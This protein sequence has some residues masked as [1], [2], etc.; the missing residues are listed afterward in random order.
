MSTMSVVASRYA[1]ALIEAL[2]AD[3]AQSADAGLDQ[4]RRIE[5]LLEI[6][7]DARKLLVNPVIPSARRR[8]FVGEINRSLGL[9]ARVGRLLGLI[10]ERRRLDIL[11][12]LIEAYQ[13]L[14]DERTA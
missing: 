5:S 9:D 7:P 14:L 13:Q 3:S 2:A 6:E 1:R 11:D 4:L 8:R 12:E 10:V